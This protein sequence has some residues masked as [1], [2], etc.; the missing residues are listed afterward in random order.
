MTTKAQ[1]GWHIH[2][3]S[4]LGFPLCSPSPTPRMCWDTSLML[5]Y[6]TVPIPLPLS[7]PCP[8]TGP[9]AAATPR[10]IWGQGILPGE[11]TTAVSS[12]P[13]T[14]GELPP[15]MTQVDRPSTARDTQCSTAIILFP[16]IIPNIPQDPDK[17]ISFNT[18]HK[19]CRF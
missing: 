10:N 4:Q 18:H 11:E 15:S 2:S 14:P 17:Q 19:L 13:T 7:H 3:M 1:T 12:P 9:P 6:L 16:I 5:H 8:R